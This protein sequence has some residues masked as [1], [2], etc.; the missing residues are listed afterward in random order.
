MEDPVNSS[1]SE[2]DAQEVHVAALARQLANAKTRLAEL[3]AEVERAR[4]VVVLHGGGGAKTRRH[5]LLQLAEIPPTEERVVLATGRYA[6]EGLDDARL[7]TLF[8]ATPFAWRG[9]LVQY[10]GRLQRMYAAKHEVR[11][12]DYVDRAAPVLMRMFQ[13]RMRGY[14][15]IGYEIA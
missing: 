4:H 3:R 1:S 6:G 7:D 12:Y 10:A 11:I 14:R 8:L 9:T 15:A 13:K 2:I 5:A